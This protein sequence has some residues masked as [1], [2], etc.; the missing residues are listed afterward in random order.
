MSKFIEIDPLEME[1]NV[2]S[3]IG[4]DW[5]LITAGN[6]KKCNTMTASWGGLGV[7]WNANV[8]FAFVRPSRYTFEFLER[9]K[10]YSLSFFE[11]GYKHALQICGTKSGRDVDKMAEADL[12][13]VFDAPA[14]YFEEAELSLVCR[15][16]YTQ[17]M[18]P[19]HFLDPTL[20]SHYK[21]GDYHRI[22]VGEI[23]KVMKKIR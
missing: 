20:E 9:E 2:L 14:P 11:P 18:D 16:L 8:S 19:A 17:D 5:M 12:H 10:Y 23:V 6:D 1:D 15:K 7:L 3:R 4:K 13:P 22:Y 21:N